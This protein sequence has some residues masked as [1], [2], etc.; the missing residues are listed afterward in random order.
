MKIK[1]LIPDRVRPHKHNGLLTSSKQAR[2]P[3]IDKRTPFWQSNVKNGIS[4]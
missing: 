2:K 1:K 3:L 4:E